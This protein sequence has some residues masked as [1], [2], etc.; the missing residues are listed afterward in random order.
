M[1]TDFDFSNKQDLENSLDDTFRRI[2]LKIQQRNGK[3]CWTLIEGLP[4]FL[5]GGDNDE[6]IQKISS[7]F[8]KSFH[9]N[10]FLIENNTVLQLQGDHRE[11]IRAY[12]LDNKICKKE[13][14]IVHGI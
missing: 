1:S 5:K 8:K 6:K 7:V 3:K 9:C 11:K 13:N 10:C 14:I 4:Q 2:S 12:L